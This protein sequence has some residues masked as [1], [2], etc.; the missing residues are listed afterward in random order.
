MEN[1][2]IIQVCFKVYWQ[3][4]DKPNYKVT[5]CKKIINSKTGKILKQSQKGGSVGFWLG[6]EFIKRKD[7]NNFLE[8]IPK[9]EKLPF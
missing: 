7:L 2:D 4:K 9:T 3:F 5:K 1:F 8:R 6:K